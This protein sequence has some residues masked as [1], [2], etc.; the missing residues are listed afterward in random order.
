[1]PKCITALG[2]VYFSL[3]VFSRKNLYLD[4]T[5]KDKSPL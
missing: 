4:S 5:V 3:C 1:M 2:R